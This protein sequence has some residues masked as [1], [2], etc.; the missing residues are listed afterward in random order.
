MKNKLEQEFSSFDDK[1]T[2]KTNVYSGLL[3]V[4]INGQ[5]TVEVPTR[6][7][8]IYVRLRDSQSEL[9][10]AYNDKVSPIYDLPVL[11]KHEGGK[12]VVIGRDIDRYRDWGNW[13]AYL[14][15]HG[16]THSFN[17]EIGTGN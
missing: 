16:N 10:Q 2:K 1:V 5:K 6:K 8:Y 11:V 13:S 14:P 4:P 7:G 17:R 3:G 15:K 9:V 12:Y